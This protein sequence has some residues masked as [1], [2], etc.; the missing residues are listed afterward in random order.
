[1]ADRWACRTAAVVH[2]TASAARP[3]S[4]DRSARPDRTKSPVAVVW[5]AASVPASVLG[6]TGPGPETAPALERASGPELEWVLGLVSVP[7]SEW[8]SESAAGRRCDP[9][10]RA[11]WPRPHA[12]HSS[13]FSRSQGSLLLGQ[14]LGRR[15]SRRWLRPHIRQSRDGWPPQVWRSPCSFLPSGTRQVVPGLSWHSPQRCPRGSAAYLPRLFDR[16]GSQPPGAILGAQ[17]RM[18]V[19][20]AARARQTTA[21]RAAGS[22]QTGRPSHV[23]GS[24]TPSSFA[25]L[26]PARAEARSDIGVARSPSHRNSLRVGRTGDSDQQRQIEGMPA[27]ETTAS[28]RRVMRRTTSRALS[29]LHGMV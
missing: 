12:P 18:R 4:T 2:C 26:R 3:A 29:V 15:S 19:I 6:T 13:R 8:G 14:Q 22:R 7:A 5:E 1:M 28:P 9:F 20:P 10:R 27:P 11:Y 25:T 16:C 21:S 23:I 17:L 24:R